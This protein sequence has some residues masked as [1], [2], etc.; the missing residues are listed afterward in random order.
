MVVLR[1][2]KCVDK[3]DLGRSTE[4][5]NLSLVAVVYSEGVLCADRQEGGERA[6]CCVGWPEQ[7]RESMERRWTGA[8]ERA[9]ERNGG[10]LGERMWGGIESVVGWWK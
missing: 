4:G 2:E 8:G 7:G 9:Q 10:L 6:L 5:C 1:R 3:V